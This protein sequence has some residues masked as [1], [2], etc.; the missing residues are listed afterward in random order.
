MSPVFEVGR[1]AAPSSDQ[2]R[3]RHAA[4]T[5]L[6]LIH[7]QHQTFVAQIQQQAA[8]AHDA[9]IA[10]SWVRAA[11][12]S[13]RACVRGKFG[14]RARGGP[15]GRAAQLYHEKANPGSSFIPVV[16][17]SVLVARSHSH[18][19]I[20]QLSSH[21]GA[22]CVSAVTGCTHP[23]SPHALHVHPLHP[24]GKTRIVWTSGPG[25]FQRVLCRPAGSTE[26]LLYS[27]DNLDNL[28]G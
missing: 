5:L 19:P 3:P 6:G 25:L 4:A 11:T 7:S 13:S 21:R 1:A 28:G 14:Q 27:V 16:P 26:T 22:S 20:V 15:R 18:R 23:L 8:V 9:C 2:A 17:F 12:D 10:A 24:V